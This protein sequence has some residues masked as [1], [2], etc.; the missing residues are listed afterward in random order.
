MVDNTNF[1][2]LY[3]LLINEVAGTPVIFIFLSI[4]LIGFI[5]AF[6]RFPNSVTI[7]IIGIFLLIMA[8]FFP[9]I[10]GLVIA[11]IGI[12]VAWIGIKMY[13]G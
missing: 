4:A 2:D 5:G 8:A 10:A 3:D 12:F 13:R 11:V 6:L 9:I 1:L 7:M